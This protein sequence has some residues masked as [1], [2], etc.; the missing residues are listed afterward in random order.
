MDKYYHLTTE[1]FKKAK[2]AKQKERTSK[3][4]QFAIPKEE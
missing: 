1:S 2:I 3:T 4:P